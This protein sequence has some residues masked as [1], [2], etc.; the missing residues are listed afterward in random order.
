MEF[1]LKLL[2]LDNATGFQSEIMKILFVKHLKVE[3]IVIA[4]GHPQCHMISRTNTC[5]YKKPI[6]N[7]IYS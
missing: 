6:K 3:P 4:A 1:L 5:N 2:C 7:I